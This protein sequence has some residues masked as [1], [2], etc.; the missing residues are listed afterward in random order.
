MKLK[1]NDFLKTTLVL[2][3]SSLSLLFNMAM[4]EPAY[5]YTKQTYRSGQHT[6]VA[7][8]GWRDND[9][10]TI[11]M[12]YGYFNHNWEEELDIP[13]GENNRFTSGEADRGQPTHFLPRRNRFTFD[14]I[15][16]GDFGEDDELVW[17]VTSPN[18]LTR[19][20]YGTLRED[21]KINNITIM[22][23]T[24][25]LGAGTSDEETRA[26]IPPVVELIGDEIRTARV[27]EPV[28]FQTRVT[29]DGVPTPFDPM[30]LVRL[31]GGAAAAF[32]TPEMVRNMMMSM[33]P[34]KPTVAK[35][36]GL[37]LSWNVYRAPE[38]MTEGV[39]DLVHFDPPQIKPWEDTRPSAN[40]PW[41][42]LW[43]PPK[44]PEDGIH[45]VTVSFDEPGTYVLWGRA[46]DGGLFKDQY[47]TV[48]VTP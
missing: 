29:D 16:P 6:E 18:G 45:D 21:Y 34:Q 39:Q 9:D 15:M 8:E 40:S 38:Q 2:L 24:G 7:Y 26:N 1:P 19:S 30:R 5:E 47:V 3:A 43:I 12:T 44:L 10:G 17:Q 20:A 32:A 35:N 4:A 31:L 41:S 22:S 27:G 46:D 14:V 11:T 23:E 36:N 48:N 33:P 13:I 42:W 37:F 25:S 28:T